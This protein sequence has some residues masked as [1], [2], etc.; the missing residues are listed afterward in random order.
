MCP[1][2]RLEL[3][4]ATLPI[5]LG[6]CGRD[7]HVEGVRAGG[8]AAGRAVRALAEDPG[9]PGLGEVRSLLEAGRAAE[10][11]QRLAGLQGFAAELLRARAAL[12]GGDAVGALRA[13]ETARELAPDSVELWATE[14][15]V[16]A[17]LDRLPGARDALA[18]GL[19]RAGGAGARDLAALER[20]RGVIEL[21]TS[22]HGREALEA[23]ER[24]RARDAELPFLRWPLA[25]AHVLVGRSR[26]PDAPGDA[27]AHARAARESVPALAE[28][29][30]LE[31]EA[32]AANLDLEA[33]LVLYEELE[34][35]GHDLGD[36]PA[37]LHQRCATLLLL[38]RDRAGAV[39]H[40]LAARS[41]GMSDEG[42]GFGAQCLAE[43][44]R[45]AHE[46]G[47]ARLR[48]EDWAAAEAEFRRALELD[49]G[50]LEARNQQGL[51]AFRREDYRSAAGAWEELLADAE[52]RGVRLEDPVP[53]D[54]AR[55]W[56]L[57][58]EP[59]RSRAVLEG[60]LGREP[61]GPWSEPARELLT[62]LEAEAL[63]DR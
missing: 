30:E 24:A 61:D 43:E 28:A 1:P 25:Q 8:G 57:A 46:R 60:Y 23:L 52:L 38:E 32:L 40:Y 27:L 36:T 62:A 37:V 10:A 51:A 49:P 5:A 13:L 53:L 9:P 35:E 54:L 22:G 14:A 31:A 18:E 26:L 3:L 11:E 44:A 50:D 45:A 15:E 58:G 19:R 21:R 4:L 59:G 20:A 7:E 63:A 47:L 56:R 48:A 17:A 12:L 41:R 29:R 39:R 33:A 16:L 55:A 2:V 6:S 34:R 42:L